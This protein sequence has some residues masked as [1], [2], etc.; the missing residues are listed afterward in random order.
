MIW[1]LRHGEAARPNG[2]K[3]ADRPLTELGK[4]QAALAGH[5]LRERAP[6][7]AAVLTSPKLRARETAELAVAAHGKAPEP[8]VVAAAGVAG[9]LAYSG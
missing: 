6:R 7:I 2:V 3:D 1:I 8:L 9:L 5:G 4:H